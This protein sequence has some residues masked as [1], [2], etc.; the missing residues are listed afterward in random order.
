MAWRRP[1]SH[2]WQLRQT[3]DTCASGGDAAKAAAAGAGTAA[4]YA[5]RARL[6]AAVFDTR[7][8]EPW[9]PPSPARSVATGVLAEVR[10]D[11]VVLDTRHG[12]EFFA[13]SPG[14]VTWAGAYT[15]PSALHPGDDIIVRYRAP[16]AGTADLLIAE[17]VWARIGRV[18]GAIIEAD[19]PEFLVDAG[20]K[21]GTPRRVVLA[22][23]TAR[24]V[25]VRFPRLEPGYLLD[26]IGTRQGDHLL[27]VA[28]ATA[29]PP[30]RAGRPPPA[31]RVT[32][33]VPVPISGSAV[34]HEPDDEPPGLLGLGY[35]ALDP[36]S[37][38]QPAGGTGCVRLPYLSL[39]SAVRIG[40][41]CA[42]R[43]AVLPVT[44]DGAMARL[45]CDRCV[46][47]GTSPKGRVA[48]L[49]VAAFAELGGNLEDGCFN[50]T[51]TTNL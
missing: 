22:T 32:G 51:M 13:L 34:W 2:F 18:A 35:P 20:R 50:A 19:G 1:Q 16:G 17:R 38:T 3:A 25:Q 11:A 31:P 46:R 36:E 9:T 43:S 12:T 7:G 26:V 5:R 10:E 6:R 27:A 33:P 45:F 30:Y 49:T 8:H 15:A 39:G 41:E 40:N 28:P 21:D 48:D 47:C 14:T 44:S 24:Q 37:G 4:W 42:G 23:A 29:Q